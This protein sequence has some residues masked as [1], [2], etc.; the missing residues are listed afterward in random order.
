MGN[1]VKDIKESYYC[2]VDEHGQWRESPIG[3]LYSCKCSN[4]SIEL[5]KF[6]IDV[7]INSDDVS[8]ETKI[9]ICNH[10]INIKDTNEMINDIRAKAS[11]IG[12]NY[13]KPLSY[14]NTSLK[15]SEDN[16]N[17]TS[18]L[19]ERFI[20]D[21]MYDR[22]PDDKNW[23][24]MKKTLVEFY[25]SHNDVRNNLA[26]NIKTVNVSKDNEFDSDSFFEELSK[27][28]L[29]LRQ[30]IFELE[31]R[32][33]NDSNFVSYFN[34][35]LSK[36]AIL[37]DNVKED[38]LRLIRFLNNKVDSDNS[39]RYEEKIIEKQI[40]NNTET[41]EIEEETVESKEETVEIEKEEVEDN[42]D[43]IEIEEDNEVE[44]GVD[45]EET[46]D[47]DL[48]DSE[49]EF[50]V[51]DNYTDD[52]YDYGDGDYSQDDIKNIISE[53]GNMAMNVNN[54]TDD[55][56]DT[57]ELDDMDIFDDDTIDDNTSEESGISSIEEVTNRLRKYK[58]GLNNE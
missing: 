49:K 23:K 36:D 45:I 58:E 15:I 12:K 37:D 9:F 33:N 19:G 42:D 13:L 55:K 3:V 5:I 20:R 24:R 39:L 50:N 27:L 41:V 52:E 8:S 44:I 7:V 11:D 30:Q 6:I 1:L 16:K 14:N 38:R 47:T 40:D 32:L 51:D 54:G 10:G 57:L 26:L 48:E 53:L 22:Y 29:Y 28:Q 46:E 35:L 31:V 4:K 2:L 21:L 34:Y 25:G 18:I 56:S 43:T 17:L